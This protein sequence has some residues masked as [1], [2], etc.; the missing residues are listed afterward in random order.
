MK[1]NS[2]LGTRILEQ[3]IQTAI[4]KLKAETIVIEAQVHAIA[5]YENKGF[6]PFGEEFLEDGIPHI[7]MRWD[8]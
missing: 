7:K 4:E 2:G 8:M 5:L 6:I 1:R 3:A